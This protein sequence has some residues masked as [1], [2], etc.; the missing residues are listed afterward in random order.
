LIVWTK[1]ERSTGPPLAL[2]LIIKTEKGQKN[3][4]LNG[5]S[6]RDLYDAGKI[7]LPV[8]LSGQL[9][10]VVLLADDRPVDYH[11]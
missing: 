3:S 6:E 11:T 2:P 8:E 1:F 7:A 5:D 10:D 4:F 9:G